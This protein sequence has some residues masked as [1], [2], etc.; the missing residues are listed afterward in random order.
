MVG[1]VQAKLTGA[2]LPELDSSS[3]KTLLDQT[4]I[5]VYEINPQ[6]FASV[7]VNGAVTEQVTNTTTN[8]V[9]SN[10]NTLTTRTTT[11]DTN[12]VNTIIRNIHIVQN[13]A[14]TEISRTVNETNG[15]SQTSSST[16]V[17]SSDSTSVSQ[18]DK[19]STTTTEKSRETKI[20]PTLVIGLHQDIVGVKTE[21]FN[22]QAGVAASAVAGV[23][24]IIF[25][26][27]ASVSGNFTVANENARL[28]S[29]KLE[30]NY[31][32]GARLGLSKEL[33]GNGDTIPSLGFDFNPNDVANA[34]EKQEV[35]LENLLEKI[36][37]DDRG[38]LNVAELE[39]I[40][41]DLEGQANKKDPKDINLL[42]EIALMRKFLKDTRAAIASIPETDAIARKLL[43]KNSMTQYKSA[44]RDALLASNKGFHLAG[45][46]V[47]FVPGIAAVFLGLN[48][49]NVA[50]YATKTGKDGFEARLTQKQLKIED[51]PELKMGTSGSILIDTAALENGHVSLQSGLVAKPS[52]N[53][54][55]EVVP[56]AGNRIRF[57]QV[58]SRTGEGIVTMG[59]VIDQVPAASEAARDSTVIPATPEEAVELRNIY[60]RNTFS[61][62]ERSK[63]YGLSRSNGHMVAALNLIIAGKYAEAKAE[64]AKGGAPLKFISDK[65][66]KIPDTTGHLKSFLDHLLLVTSGSRKTREDSNVT[67]AQM[68]AEQKKNESAFRKLLSIPASDAVAVAEYAKIQSGLNQTGSPTDKVALAPLSSLVGAGYRDIAGTVSFSQVGSVGGKKQQRTLGGLFRFSGDM[69]VMAAAIPV[70]SPQMKAMILKNAEDSGAFAKNLNLA[71]EVL[72]RANLTELK[73]EEYREYLLNGTMPKRYEGL[74]DLAIRPK[75]LATRAALPGATCFNDVFAL[76]F[77]LVTVKGRTV[78]TSTPI[79]DLTPTGSLVTASD[80]YDGTGGVGS[81]TFGLNLSQIVTETVINRAVTKV[82]ETASRSTEEKTETNPKVT[83]VV[84]EKVT[85]E[86]PT[87]PV[88]PTDPTTQP[89][90]EVFDGP[91]GTPVTPIGPGGGT[92]T[93]TLDQPIVTP[94]PGSGGTPVNPATDPFGVG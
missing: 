81:G 77:P 56:T 85:I 53:G 1:K 50:G 73:P 57:Q 94:T 43:I 33:R 60:D 59:I 65:V 3:M 68:V 80:R 24:G 89:G 14:G 7:G 74:L 23:D 86:K 4:A 54:S 93:P 27:T 35:R 90:G 36:D 61:D 22:A 37:I 38:Q 39:K 62:A 63:I 47:T 26:I 92:S 71:N 41:A 8:L 78:E 83:T 10:T 69:Q 18:T 67:N 30:G 31:V 52:A 88:T 2:G 15:G 55:S 91:V 32:F 5:R 40:L 19:G 11:T 84:E 9:E 34:I 44:Y 12:T 42:S 82:V 28:Q 49:Q 51:I 20:Q 13:S 45:L 25:P 17:S 72:K 29:G 48:V 76:A 70:D 75:F 46:N 16:R 87:D 58:E 6:V 66:T 64:L 79:S 21:R